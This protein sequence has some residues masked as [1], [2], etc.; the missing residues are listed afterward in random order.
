LFQLDATK[1]RNA[2]VL[3]S[4]FIPLIRKTIFLPSLTY[5]K[6]DDLD[7]LD[8]SDSESEF[9]R[10][11]LGGQLFFK[12]VL[13]VLKRFGAAGAVFHLDASHENAQGQYVPFSSELNCVP[14]V[15]VDREVG[16]DLRQ[17]AAYCPKARL[18]LDAHEFKEA[19]TGNLVAKLPG[20][21]DRCMIISTHTDGQNAIEENG[22]IACIAIAEHYAQLPK[23]ERP[24]T[25]IFNLVTGHMGPN[26]PQTQGFV[27]R[28]PELIRKAT[29][30]ITLEH[31]G[32]T[33]WIDDDKKGYKATGRPEFA[34]A[35][36]SETPI[37]RYLMR[38]YKDTPLLTGIALLRPFFDT[39]MARFLARD[40]YLAKLL[41]PIVAT[42]GLPAY[43]GVGAP[44]HQAGVPSIGYLTGPNYLSLLT[45]TTR[46]ISSTRNVCNWS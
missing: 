13:D 9:K 19:R 20:K 22:A 42:R 23:K 36:H 27:E 29:C 15:L 6:N 43:L 11:W 31:L 45:R 12:G 46:W 17:R 28:H 38:S 8:E 34:A 26:L 33:E 30:A 4:G 25:L 35:F 39:P 32:A 3:V 1:V 24:R 41:R 16:N 5:A 18:T 10:P 2:I 21:S 37:R 7:R 40:N 44:L 14:A